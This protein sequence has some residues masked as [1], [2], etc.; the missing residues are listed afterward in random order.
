MPRSA[1][2]AVLS[3]LTAACAGGDDGPPPAA[4]TGT[5]VF[6]VNEDGWN[7]VWTMKADGTARARLTE[8]APP[9][10]D[11][12]GSATPAWSPSRDRIAFV[13]TGETREE[14]EAAREVWVMAADGGDRR[15]LTANQV[16][17]FRPTW[18]PDAE[19]LAFA[20]DPG[21]GTE[22]ARGQI[23]VLELESGHES[24]LVD[25]AGKR[26]LTFITDVAWSPDG[27][28]LAF[29]RSRVVDGA[30]R[31]AIYAIRAD[32]GGERLVAEDAGQP[33]W[34]PD[35]ERLA[36]A[37]TRDRFGET[38]FHDCAPSGEIYVSE[39]DGSGA[40][41]ITRDRASDGAPTWSPDGTKLLFVSD[42]S[43]PERHEYELYV[44][45]AAGGAPQRLTTN[46]V[47]DLEPDWAG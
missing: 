43:S 22:Q 5:I 19:R 40:R 8:A 2:L 11:A 45:L 7:S 1:V 16:P 28:R 35:G 6:T 41:R 26:E 36:F 13:S 18:S 23:V 4:P 14:S 44:V 47:W 15:R 27:E 17:D 29:T 46:D 3:A 30:F 31:S 33:S 25:D 21:W 38:C 37:S 39:A 24:V 32:G 12:A 20:R 42:R 10:T 34:S 9:D